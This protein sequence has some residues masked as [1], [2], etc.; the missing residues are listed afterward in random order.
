[1]HPLPALES[2]DAASPAPPLSRPRLRLPAL[3]LPP[4]R[5]LPRRPPRPRRGPA[6]RP[7]SANS[8]R[9]SEPLA[10]GRDGR[11]VA[12][13][14][15]RAE[16]VLAGRARGGAWIRSAARSHPRHP[17]VEGED[18]VRHQ[19]RALLL[20]LLGGRRA[21]A[22][23]HSPHDALARSTRSPSRR[24]RPCS[25]RLDALNAGRARELSVEGAALPVSEVRALPRRAVARRR[26]FDRRARV[27]HREEAVRRRRLRGARGEELRRVEGPRHG[28]CLRGARRRHAHEVGLPAHRQGSGRARRRW[29][30]TPPRQ[31]S[32]V[33]RATSRSARRAIGITARPKTSC[34]ARSRPTPARRS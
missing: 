10:R 25:R 31:Y 1:M 32:R 4:R 7:P 9:R 17:R 20:Q 28:V 24:G 3:R 6:L 8:R 18:A 16:Q 26:R 27:R 19:A 5:L 33:S 30:G 29:P 21:R 23:P 14:G 13:V 15:A 34:S 22:R 11:Q 12:R 2:R